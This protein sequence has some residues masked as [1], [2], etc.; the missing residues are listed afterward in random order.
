MRAHRMFARRMRNP[1]SD[2]GDGN[3][4]RATSDGATMTFFGV[5]LALLLILLIIIVGTRVVLS[6]SPDIPPADPRSFPLDDLGF[7][8]GGAKRAVEAAVVA[9]HDEGRVAPGSRRSALVAAGPPPVGGQTI[10]RTVYDAIA[11]AGETRLA[12]VTRIVAGSPAT[13]ATR[14]GLQTAYLVPPAEQ[15]RRLRRLRRTFLIMVAVGVAGLPFAAA[16]GDLGAFFYL[17]AAFMM[18]VVAA[19]ATIVP[20]TTHAGRRLLRDARVLARS[21]GLGGIPG[22]RGVAVALFGPIVLWRTDPLLARQLGLP[23][24]ATSS[25]GSHASSSGGDSSYDSGSSCGGGSGCG[26]GGG[27]GGGSGGCGGGSSCGGGGCGGGG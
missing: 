1:G 25:G 24:V 22:Q 3:R 5:Y 2:R 7:L 11:A 20:P 16:A 15:A 27:C 26:G 18:S 8:A 4:W 10:T 17:P 13:R 19:V 14:A 9:L 21:L 23:F 12:R 6:R